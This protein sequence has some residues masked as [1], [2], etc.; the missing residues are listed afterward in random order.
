MQ[1]IFTAAQLQ[2]RRACRARRVAGRGRRSV[3]KSIVAFLTAI[4]PSENQGQKDLFKDPF[5][6]R[7]MNPLTLAQGTTDHDSSPFGPCS[8][9]LG[10]Q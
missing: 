1:W 5:S 2:L 6:F 7:L 9:S 8:V 4:R 10:Q 3:E